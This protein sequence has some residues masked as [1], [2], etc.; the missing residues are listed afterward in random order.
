MPIVD[1]VII[2]YSGGEML[3]NLLAKLPKFHNDTVINVIVQSAKQSV[4][5]NINAG[6]SKVISDYFLIFND[7]WEPTQDH[8]LDRMLEP[9]LNDDYGP[10]DGVSCRIVMDTGIINHC[11]YIITPHGEVLM[12]GDGEVHDNIIGDNSPFKSGH[13]KYAHPVLLRTAVFRALGGYD[14]SFEGSQFADIDFVYRF[15]HRYNFYYI[16]D[17]IILHH[18]G[19]DKNTKNI[20]S[21]A[22]VVNGDKFRRKHNFPIPRDGKLKKTRRTNVK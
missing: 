1:M 5:R 4:A 14:E 15:G 19:H 2:S 10:V 18:F 16:D 7:D 6:E 21:H 22:R 17:V 9:L 20:R 3:E 8:W 13:I 11:G 12:R